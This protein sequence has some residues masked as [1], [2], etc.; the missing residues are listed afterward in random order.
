MNSQITKTR[1]WAISLGAKD[2]DQEVERKKEHLRSALQRFREHAIVLTSRIAATFP[3]L[4][5]HDA[6]HLDAL[7]ETADLIAGEGYPLNPLA[8]C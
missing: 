1:L 3:Q 8:G 7:W 4:T 2:P 5:V 6:T